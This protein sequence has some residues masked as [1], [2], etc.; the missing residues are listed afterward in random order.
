[1][2][3]LLQNLVGNALKFHKNGV[4]PIVKIRSRL[5]NGANGHS[6]G[7]SPSGDLCEITVE[8]NG[9]GFDEIYAD[10]IFT[11]FQ[12]LHSRES[13]DGTGIG[14]AICR[15]IVERHGGSIRASNATDSGSTFTVTL[16]VHQNRVEE[17]P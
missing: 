4:S 3:Q 9:I 12:R 17:T 13:Y 7:E 6:P 8:D 14:L 11:V 5:L 15:R 10:R 16:P 1:M 2:R